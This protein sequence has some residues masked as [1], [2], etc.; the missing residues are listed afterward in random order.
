MKR[1]ASELGLNVVSTKSSVRYQI[2]LFNYHT[3]YEFGFSDW[4]ICTSPVNLQD[5]VWTK[6]NSLHLVI[7]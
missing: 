6:N 4:V 5:D 2:L 7:N 1:S 3:L